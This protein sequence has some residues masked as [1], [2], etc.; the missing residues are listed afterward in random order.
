MSD[1]RYRT[2]NSNH[3]NEVHELLDRSRCCVRTK[4]IASAVALL[5]LADRE[6]RRHLDCTDPHRPCSVTSCT[7]FAPHSPSS[8]CWRAV[9]ATRPQVFR[10]VSVSCPALTW[11]CQT[12]VGSA[13]AGV[14]SHSPCRPAGRYCSRRC[15][16]GAAPPHRWRRSFSP[17]HTSDSSSLSLLAPLFPPAL[18]P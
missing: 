9:S 8:H 16:S 2:L 12:H 17:V 18:P 10:R 5:V 1:I 3:G 4:K 7:L 6:R 14:H 15:V 13:T 11:A